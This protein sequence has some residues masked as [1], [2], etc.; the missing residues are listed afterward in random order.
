LDGKKD[1]EQKIGIEKFIEACRSYVSS[2]SDER[3]IFVDQLGR[4]AD[5]DH[6]YYTMDLSFMESVIWVFQNMYSQNLV[7]KGFNIQWYCPS[8]ATSL[9]NSEVNE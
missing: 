2:T 1:I 4:W 8:C 6:A 3:K 7:Y 5:M 9:S